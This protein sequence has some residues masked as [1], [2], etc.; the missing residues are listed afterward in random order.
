ML[1]NIYYRNR[2]WAT[3]PWGV[4]SHLHFD[5]RR[6]G[7]RW[8][9]SYQ[10]HQLP[11]LLVQDFGP[12]RRKLA[13]LITSIAL[14]SLF[15]YLSWRQPSPGQLDP[16]PVFPSLKWFRYPYEVNPENRPPTYPP[17]WF[18]YPLAVKPEER[19][20]AEYTELGRIAVVPDSNGRTLVT[21]GYDGTILRTVDGGSSGL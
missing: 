7:E 6:E 1:S 12:E 18:W 11:E 17:N 4:S 10:P 8:N 16:P 5:L 21:A 20:P 19:S 15:G 9:Q 14:L 13:A 3:E 2:F